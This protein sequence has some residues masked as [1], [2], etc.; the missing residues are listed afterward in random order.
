ME[1]LEIMENNFWKNKKILITGYEGFLGSHLTKT[2][3]CLGAKLWGLDIKVYRK[4]TILSTQDLNKVRVIKGRVENFPLVSRIINKNK[5]EFI[6]H[7][8]AQSLVGPALNN[9]IKTFTTN[10]CGTWNVLEASRHNKLV[11]AI[12]IASSDKAYGIQNKLPYKETSPIA[13]CHPYDVSKSCADLL[14]FTYFHTFNLPICITRCGNIFGPGDFN[15]SRII[16]DAIRSIIKNKTLVIR[17]DGKFTRDYIYIKDIISGYLL[18]ARKMISLKLYGE[19]F[20]FSNES[21]ISVL[22]LVKIISKISGQN[23]PDYKITNQAKYEIKYQFLSSLK[24]RKIL[25]WKPV[26]TLENGLKETI[27]WYQNY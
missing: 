5:I 16:P 3:L 22:E 2:L 12:I 21:P 1:G 13:G 27:K 10:I 26:Y 15:F 19:A 8:A 4:Q 20:N 11:K 9:P 14:A 18:L 7:L 25:G 6:F 23:K 24:A 17:S